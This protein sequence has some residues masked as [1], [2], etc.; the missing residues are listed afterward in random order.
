MT[1]T[2]FLIKAR[3]NPVVERQCMTDTF[4]LCFSICLGN[5]LAATIK[6]LKNAC[7]CWLGNPSSWDLP[8][9][10]KDKC[11]KHRNTSRKVF[12]RKILI[13]IS[14]FHF[15]QLIRQ[16]SCSAGDLGLILGLGRSPEGGHGNP[17][18]VFLPGECPW[19]EE[20]GGLQSM[21]PRRVGH[22]WATKH[23]RAQGVIMRISNDSLSCV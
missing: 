10:H 11:K 7:A 14:S 6:N 20:P 13:I 1:W 18:P 8:W 16:Q 21:G 12:C 15:W 17:T 22:D 23:S 5:N 19:I 2:C 9:E 4:I 3:I